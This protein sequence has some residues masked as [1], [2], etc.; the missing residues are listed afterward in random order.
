MNFKMSIRYTCTFDLC[1][2]WGKSQTYEALGTFCIGPGQHT[3]IKIR[4][5]D[6][7]RL[8]VKKYIKIYRSWKPG[9]KFCND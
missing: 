4:I 2:N 1:F 7:S 3:G 8:S 6:W 5:F 9:A